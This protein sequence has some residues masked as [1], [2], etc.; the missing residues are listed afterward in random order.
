MANVLHLIDANQRRWAAMRFA[1]D[2]IDEFKKAATVGLANKSRY[3]EIAT[4]F[5]QIH[6]KPIP[7][8]VIAVA[9]YRESTANFSKQLAQGDPLN[10]VSTHVPRGEGPYGAHGGHDAFYWSAIVALEGSGATTWDDWSAGGTLTFLEIKYNG[11]AYANHGVPSPY[12]WSGTDQ[13]SIGKVEVDG[14]PIMPVVDKQLGCAGIIRYMAGLDASITFTGAPPPPPIAK[15]SQPIPAPTPAPVPVP[16]PVPTPAPTPVPTPPP[17]P[18]VPSMGALFPALLQIVLG[19]PALMSLVGSLISNPTAVQA[20]TQVL[21]GLSTQVASGATP[22]QAIQNLILTQYDL[23][24]AALVVQA[25]A[26]KLGVTTAWT[27]DQ[28]REMAALV[29]RSYIANTKAGK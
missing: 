7:W 12:I 28:A 25:E 22:A 8:F 1:S 21:T 19:S 23:D 17:T 20:V 6:G 27:Q 29:I 16:V 15:P 14:G 26:T 9:H 10:Q 18:T 11:P 2:R 4:G 13:Y 5:Q 24:Q 3:Q